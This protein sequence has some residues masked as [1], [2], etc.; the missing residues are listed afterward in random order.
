MKSTTKVIFRSFNII[1]RHYIF[2]LISPFLLSFVILTGIFLLDKLF[3]AID[4]LV[5]KG[6]P[7]IK[8]M[9]FLLYTAPAIISTTVPTSLLVA[10]IIVFGRAGEDREDIILL[11]SGIPVYRILFSLLIP[12]M[13]ISSFMIFFNGYILPRANLEWRKILYSIYSKKPSARIEPGEFIEDFKGYTL[14][15]E[16]M[17]SKTNEI[18]NVMLYNKVRTRTPTT[19]LASRGR[20]IPYYDRDKLLVELYNADIHEVKDS[21]Y[22]W[23]RSDT[24]SVLLRISKEMKE[25]NLHPGRESEYTFSLI[26]RKLKEVKEMKNIPLD[27]LK[28]RRNRLWHE[29]Y[30]KISLALISFVFLFLGPSIGLLVRKSNIGTG[31][32]IGLIIFSIY[33]LLAAAFENL[34]YQGKVNALLSAFAPF[35]FFLLPSIFIFWRVFLRNEL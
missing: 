4:L 29:F 13:V 7:L 26:L 11:S 12:V 28:I 15:V 19:I 24:F 27:I 21:T 23:I 22:R 17:D 30:K 31:Y 35:F 6:I 10:L 20:I 9:E 34:G 32:V 3:L 14:Y 33:Y 8:I 2:S 5:R 25:Y 16:R 1:H 18:Y